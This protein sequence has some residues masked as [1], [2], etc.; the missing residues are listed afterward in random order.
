MSETTNERFPR[1]DDQGRI[2]F[3][4]DL[5]GIVGA[6]LVIG[7]VSLVVLDWGFALIGLGEY[8][9]A[10]GWLALILPA[11]VFVEEFRA[12]NYGPARIVAALVA[13][14]AGVTLGLATAGAVSALP[15]LLSGGLGATVAALVYALI[16]FVGVRWLERRTG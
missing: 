7:L 4:T 14:A 15:S 1:R 2:I 13:A 3:F 10:N 12:W 6:G 11:W 8:G 5:L 9:R 16:W